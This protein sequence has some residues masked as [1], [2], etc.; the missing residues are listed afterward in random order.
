M[1]AL[2]FTGENGRCVLYGT[3][4]SLPNPGESVVIKDARMV[5]RVAVVGFLGLAGGGPKKGSD[6]R[7][8]RPVPRTTCVAK[9]AAECTPEAAAAID[10]WPNWE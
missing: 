6:T 8:T 2:I 5:L 7:I 3:I 10:A 1:K 9:Q 4:E